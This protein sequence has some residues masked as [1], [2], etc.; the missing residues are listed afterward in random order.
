MA[1]TLTIVHP[2][3]TVKKTGHTADSDHRYPIF[4][5][6]VCYLAQLHPDKSLD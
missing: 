1:D 5:F 2:E 4:H 3:T 6:W